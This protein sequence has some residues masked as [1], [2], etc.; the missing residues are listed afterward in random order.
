MSEQPIRWGILG[1]ADFAQRQMAPAIHSARGAVLAALG[2]SSPEKAAPFQSLNPD[3]RILD[4]YDAV[5]QDPDIDAVYIP[6]PNALHV[7]WTEKALRAGKH[8]LT[9]KPIAMKAEEID[10]LI[11]VR[12]ETGLQ[13]AEAY[14]IVHHPQWQRVREMLKG[15]SIGTLRH[16]TGFFGFNNV[17][18]SNI[19]N[20]A[21][22][23][24]GIIP[25]I[26]VYLYGSTRWATGEEPAEI[27]AADLTWENG[28]D[29]SASVAARFPGFTAN[30]LTTMRIDN[31]Q[32]MVFLG[33]AGAIE[34]HTPFNAQ[35]YGEA[36]ISLRHGMTVTEERFPDAAQ[37]V[38]QVEAFGAAIRGERPFP[39][40]L[41]D[42]RGTQA[43]IDSVYAAG[44]PPK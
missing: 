36:R 17:D 37:Y 30:W 32:R 11:A 38:L 27:T 8:V 16:V 34:V 33:D 10:R 3:L 5:L 18:L 44:N 43:V 1:A 35:S 13:A 25:D 21:G 28:V 6:L 14:M 12:D 23:G 4:G 2:T 39:W 20:R 9:E 42:A 31:A 7:E 41:E 29:V 19:R 26:G 24:G 15:G 40:T 22:D